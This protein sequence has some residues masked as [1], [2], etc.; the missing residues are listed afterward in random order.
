MSH[1]SPDAEALNATVRPAPWTVFALEESCPRTTP[2]ARRLIAAAQD[3]VASTVSSCAAQF[4]TSPVCV[5]A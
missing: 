1:A 3:A 4:T 5:P 2:S